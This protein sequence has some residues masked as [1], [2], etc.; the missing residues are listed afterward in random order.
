VIVNGHARAL[1][2]EAERDAAA[3]S[4]GGSGHQDDFVT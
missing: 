1:L 3:D 2:R 4:L